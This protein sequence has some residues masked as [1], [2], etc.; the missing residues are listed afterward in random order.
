MWGNR[1]L[2]A[3]VLITMVKTSSSQEVVQRGCACFMIA[4][5]TGAAGGRGKE[6]TW[7]YRQ[8]ELGVSGEIA[9]RG[10]NV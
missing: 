1:G 9:G 3:A 6:H 7:G 4:A 10:G 2:S 8:L 5:A